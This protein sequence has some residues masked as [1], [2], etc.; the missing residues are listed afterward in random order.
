MLLIFS[1]TC[2]H[3]GINSELI[4]TSARRGLKAPESYFSIIAGI[5]NIIIHLD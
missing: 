4:K 3:A 2:T 5:T 1:K